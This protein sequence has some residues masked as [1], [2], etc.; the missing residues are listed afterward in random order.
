MAGNVAAFVKRL[1]KE[2]GL[3]QEQLA[4]LAGVSR[5][6]IIQIEKGQKEHGY[7]TIE[8]VVMALGGNVEEIRGEP[9]GNQPPP[10]PLNDDQE[11]L[12][13][14][15]GA[16]GAEDQARLLDMARRLSASAA[17]LP[18]T[19]ESKPGRAKKGSRRS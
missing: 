19:L 17:G 8:S 11:T 3:T 7:S 13:Q 15:F 14:R 1:R 10:A 16:L 2:R 6:T 18:P 9:R 5:D 4:Q 12:L